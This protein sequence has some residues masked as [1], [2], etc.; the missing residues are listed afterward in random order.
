MTYENGMMIVTLTILVHLIQRHEKNIL[1]SVE[2]SI[3]SFKILPKTSY[4]CGDCDLIILLYESCVVETI[5][6]ICKDFN[7]IPDTTI[8]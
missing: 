8:K 6:P 5:P 7:F 4:E 1:L 2:I 3:I